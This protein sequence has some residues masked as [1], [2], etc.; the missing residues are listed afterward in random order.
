[1]VDATAIADLKTIVLDAGPSVPDLIALAWASASTYRDSDKRGGAN[2]A[3]IRLAPN[4]NWPVNN[5][6]RLDRVLSALE[7]VKAEFDA[8]A[9]GGT[10]ISISDLI[11]LSGC[12]AVER[13]AKDAGHEIKVPFVPGRTDA[14]QE[15]TDEQQMN[16]LQ[17]VADGFR[18]YINTDVR[19]SVP[20]EHLFLDRAA[21]LKLTAP[22]W[23]ALTG[24]LRVLDQNYDGSPIGRFTDQP[25][26][27]TNDF[28]AVLCSTENDWVPRDEGETVFDV[29]NRRTGE[30]Q[31]SASRCDLVFGANAT[32]RQISELY[33]GK[34]GATLLVRAFARAWHKVMML[35]RFDVP[36][37]RR[38]ALSIC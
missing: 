2:G 11:V 35:D 33:S 21:L 8:S 28:F 18:N 6:D 19:F 25:G 24:G 27:L 37:A 20:A 16:Y 5:P 36:D 10:K 32:L 1:M 3:R 38:A 23:T 29:V 31:Y 22:E 30:T 14:M 9:P 4:R 15:M 7:K 13:A 26:L 17:P 34:D 12:A